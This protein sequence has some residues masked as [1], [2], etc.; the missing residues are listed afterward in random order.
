MY[1]SLWSPEVSLGIPS[2]DESHKALLDKLAQLKDVSDTDFPAQYASLVACV[3]RDFRE[4]ETLME[5]IDFPGI[6]S[7]REQHAKLL[8]GLHHAACA[9]MEGD[10]ELGHHVIELLSDWFVFH[11]STMDTALSFALLCNGQSSDLHSGVRP[12]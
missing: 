7:H 8:G 12:T 4:E 10:V 11:I 9:V 6:R 5:E 1:Q 3:E 2:M